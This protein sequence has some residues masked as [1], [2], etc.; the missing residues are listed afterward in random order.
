LLQ[1]F[2]DRS[3]TVLSKLPIQWSDVAAH[4]SK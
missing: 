2:F 3:Q 1:Q 4:V